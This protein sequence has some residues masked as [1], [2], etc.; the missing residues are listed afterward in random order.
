MPSDDIME[1]FVHG[2]MAANDRQ[3]GSAITIL[4]TIVYTK[5]SGMAI[6][7]ICSVLLGLHRIAL[8]QTVF[9]S[10]IWIVGCCVSETK[11]L[12]SSASANQT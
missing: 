10:R 7:N 8:F 2:G 5:I 1:E 4:L 9:L 6:S 3:K 11:Y 12:H